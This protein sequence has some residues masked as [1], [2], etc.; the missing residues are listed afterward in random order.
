MNEQVQKYIEMQKQTYVY[1]PQCQTMEGSKPVI[2]YK[3]S[4]CSE[5]LDFIGNNY[6]IDNE[7]YINSIALDF[8]CGIGRLISLFCN[9]FKQIDGVDLSPI[10]LKHAREY[11]I[12]DNSILYQCNGYDLS[13]IPSSKYDLVYSGWVMEHIC[14]HEIRNNYF[15]EFYRV[16]VPGGKISILMEGGDKY[17][18]N[19][20][21]VDWYSNFYDAPSTN[22]TNDVRIDNIFNIVDDLVKIGYYNI[23]FTVFPL[24]KETIDNLMPPKFAGHQYTIRIMAYK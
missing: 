20:P 4:F 22:S 2:G 9:R 16:L 17:L 18:P 14:V 7:D 5:S 23:N 15:K 21:S 10:F 13:E 1:L 12:P 3:D 19:T 24:D 6:V 8:G 11:G